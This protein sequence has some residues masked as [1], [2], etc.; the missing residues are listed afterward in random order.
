M[1]REYALALSF[2]QPLRRHALPIYVRSIPVISRL[3]LACHCFR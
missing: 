2:W 1:L 3:A